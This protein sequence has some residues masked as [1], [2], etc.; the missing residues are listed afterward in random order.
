MVQP[1]IRCGKPV[2]VR[3]F[4]LCARSLEV[5]RPIPLRISITGFRVERTFSQARRGVLHFA[6]I[7]I[8]FVDSSVQDA[9]ENGS[10][11]EAAVCLRV[12]KLGGEVKISTNDE[13]ENGHG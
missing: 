2:I 9:S 11:L 12:G 7:Q 8:H 6:L 5:S 10:G 13:K 1:K 4:K 3:L